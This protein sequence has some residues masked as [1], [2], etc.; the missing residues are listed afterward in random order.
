MQQVVRLLTLERYQDA[1]D[2]LNT[3]NTVKVVIEGA[4]DEWK[5]EATSRLCSI[6]PS[7]SWALHVTKDEKKREFFSCLKKCFHI[8]ENTRDAVQTCNTSLR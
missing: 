5:A 1:V 7:S 3:L 8:L 4:G 6:R 2:A